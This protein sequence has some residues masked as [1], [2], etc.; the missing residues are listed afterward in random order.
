MPDDKR[1]VCNDC[2]YIMY[3]EEPEFCESCYLE[4]IEEDG[5]EY[6]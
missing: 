3:G 5:G 6:E 1:W 2:G 4:D